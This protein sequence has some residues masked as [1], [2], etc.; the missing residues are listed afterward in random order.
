MEQIRGRV[1]LIVATLI[2][3][4]TCAQAQWLNH[5]D[6]KIPR[7]RDGKANLS[8]PAPRASNGKPDL[9]GMW[10]TDSTP[11]A[12]M[13]RLYGPLGTFAVPGDDPLEFN[14]YMINIMADFKRED[15]PLRPEFVPLLKQ[16]GED[17]SANQNPT[18]RCLP[19][20]IPWIYG[21]PDPYKMIQTPGLTLMIFEGEP[22]R[23]IYTDGR[24][25]TR[26]PEPAWYG[27]SVG[28][29]ENDTLVVDS[30]GFKDRSWLDAFGHPHSED[31]HIVERFR[32]RDF[33]H[34]ELQ[35]TLEDPRVYTRPVTVKYTQTL[36]P[37]TDILEY[38]CN[39]NERDRAH[40]PN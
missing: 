39:E 34:M 25:H 30:V 9:S 38:V 33:G 36:V 27:Y 24:K 26:D 7:T 17:R 40:L 35:V 32:R 6:A 14:K 12:E 13:E 18:A 20:G 31:L 4:L 22:I 10:A 37:D 5:T 21:I 28:T 29:W 3:G 1:I 19:M 2:G 23:Q 15:D 11:R 16:R 8:A